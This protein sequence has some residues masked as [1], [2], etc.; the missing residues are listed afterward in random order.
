MKILKMWNRDE[1]EITK[2]RRQLRERTDPLWEA[3]VPVGPKNAH[4]HELA[5]ARSHVH[6]QLT[7]AQTSE[8][9]IQIKCFNRYRSENEHVTNSNSKKKQYAVKH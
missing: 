8:T 7:F 2:H 9:Q 1:C 6:I 5:H 3:M 4:N